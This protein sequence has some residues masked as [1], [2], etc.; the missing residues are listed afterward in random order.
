MGLLIV[1]TA[2]I[3][4]NYKYILN[5]TG[6]VGMGLVAWLVFLRVQSQGIQV[7]LII[8]HIFFCVGCLF[9]VFIC[10]IRASCRYWIYTDIYDEHV[11]LGQL[12]KRFWSSFIL[13]RD[14]LGWTT[15][16]EIDYDE[17]FYFSVVRLT[18]FIEWVWD[19]LVITVVNSSL[20]T[21][22]IIS[23]IAL[24]SYILVCYLLSLLAAWILAA[25]VFTYPSLLIPEL[26]I[27][28][29]LHHV[30]PKGEFKFCILRGIV[31]LC[32][33]YLRFLYCVE[34]ELLEWIENKD[35]YDNLWKVMNFMFC[36]GVNG[37]RAFVLLEDELRLLDP[38]SEVILSYS[39]MKLICYETI[40]M[41][42][43]GVCIAVSDL[44]TIY[45][46]ILLGVSTFNMFSELLGLYLNYRKKARQVLIESNPNNY[47]VD[48]NNFDHWPSDDK[49]ESK[50]HDSSTEFNAP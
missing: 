28:L 20:C 10:T 24:W 48:D 46:K 3:R 43:C 44:S 5:L 9:I 32:E 47:V 1:V 30:S 16:R 39:L 17:W 18:Y 25:L 40:F 45:A 14:H 19:H 4:R 27:A 42:V 29:I 23:T 41:G 15:K 8:G 26:F 7:Q 13:T 50:D 49:D 2:Y 33:I 37:S 35:E 34:F 12:Y 11:R 21:L 38:D 22:F 31:W 36:L 6:C